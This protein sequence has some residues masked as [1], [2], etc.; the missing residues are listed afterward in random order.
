MSVHSDRNGKCSGQTKVSQLNDS[1]AVNKQIL[2]FE[3]SVQNSPLMTEQNT[4]HDLI[5]VALQTK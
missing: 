2:W 3:I 4:S 5:G 1:I